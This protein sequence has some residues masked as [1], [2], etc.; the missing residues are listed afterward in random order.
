MFYTPLRLNF[1]GVERPLFGAY[2]PLVKLKSGFCNYDG[3]SYV[4]DDEF[5]V[6]ESFYE[7]YKNRFDIVK[8][9]PIRNVKP[10]KQKEPIEDGSNSPE[11]EGA[12]RADS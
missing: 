11:S 10:K 4:V 9:T 7:G 1:Y 6:T 3:S 5:E 2:M 12:N 8:K